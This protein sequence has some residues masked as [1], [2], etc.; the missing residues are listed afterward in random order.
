[1]SEENPYQA[2]QADVIEPGQQGERTLAAPRAC[3]AGS[4]WS[5]IS[6]AFSLFARSPGIWILLAL[7]LVG[8]WLVLLFI[9]LLGDIALTLFSYVLVAGMMLGCADLE[10][11]GEL[12]V[13]HLFRGFKHESMGSLVVCGAVVLGITAVIVVVVLIGT[14]AFAGMATIFAATDETLMAGGFSL[15]IVLMFLIGIALTLPIVMMTWFAP[16]LIVFHKLSVWDAMKQSFKGC[17]KNIIPFLI[18][19][20]VML[21]FSIPVGL[22]LGLALL[23]LIPVGVI[24]MYTSYKEI[25]THAA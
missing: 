8:M 13:E 1:M 22:T 7:I 15:G 11:G 10:R 14:F 21:L 16:A 4:G 12:S 25:F 17:L 9:P 2:P 23:V 18:Y 3:S 5:W 6:E 19:G 20:L 24:T